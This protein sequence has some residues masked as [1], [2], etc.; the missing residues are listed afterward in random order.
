MYSILGDKSKDK[1]KV[2]S[3]GVLDLFQFAD[4]LDIILIFVGL[5]ASVVAGS[6]YPLLIIVFGDLSTG[7]NSYQVI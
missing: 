2:K 7:F 4:K 3:V 1:E 6:T 5:S